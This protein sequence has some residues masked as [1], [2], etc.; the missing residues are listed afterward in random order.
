MAKGNYVDGFVLVIPKSK[1]AEYKKI[2]R[3]AEKVWRRFGALDYKE[4]I[5]ENLNPDTGGQK[6]VGFAGMAK[7]KKGEKVWFSYVVYK[8]RAHR[9]QVNKKVM[10]YFAKK[11][12]GQQMDMPFDMKRMAYGGF[13]VEVGG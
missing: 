5:E 11:Y 7:P 9:D 8:S 3:E 10:D 1:T 13:R 2:A 12:S 6:I 4:C